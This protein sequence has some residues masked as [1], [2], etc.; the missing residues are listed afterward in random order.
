MNTATEGSRFKLAAAA[1]QC[2]RAIVPVDLRVRWPKS[3]A[4][5]FS[6]KRVHTLRVAIKLLKLRVKEF[7]FLEV[8]RCVSLV[9]LGLHTCV[10]WACA[11][12][13][14]SLSLSLRG[15]LVELFLCVFFFVG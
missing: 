3:K 1:G 11:V 9:L 5:S 15:F 14:L 4:I 2:L 12:L 13:A 6:A 10:I 8:I 7:D